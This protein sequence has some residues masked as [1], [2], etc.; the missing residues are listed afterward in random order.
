MRKSNQNDA[1]LQQLLQSL[2]I[3][4]PTSAVQIGR[5]VG[6]LPELIKRHN[7]AVRE[8]EGVLTTHLKNPDNVPTKRPTM[9]VGG[10][11]MM[12]GNKVDA[13]DY[14]TQKIQ[15]FEE[16][17]E[18][19]VHARQAGAIAL[20]R[21]IRSFRPLECRSMVSRGRR[22]AAGLKLT[23]SDPDRKPENYGFASFE[24]VPYAHV[25]A[26]RLSGKRK[27]GSRFDLAPV[28]Q[29]I[30]WDNITLT[31]AA[32]RKNQFFSAVLLVV[33]CALYIIPL[34]VVSLLANLAALGAFVGFIRRWSDE[35]PAL[36]AA[37]IG[38]VP[39]LL[40]VVL[41]LALPMIIR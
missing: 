17:I 19:G 16:R 3:P 1:G 24:S 36:F 30:I 28:P 18:V 33:V 32:K 39:P 15:R 38:I 5:R 31:D 23:R 22:R 14:L 26:K 10:F 40:S 2:S 21:V 41:Q 27:L 29:D 9:R 8:L 35:Y 11:M 13:I 4:Y 25:V 7:D 20:T 37:F 6:T 34:I 12:G